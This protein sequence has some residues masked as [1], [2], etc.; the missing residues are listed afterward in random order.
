MPAWQRSRP[1]GGARLVKT[2]ETAATSAPDQPPCGEQNTLRPGS[3]CSSEAEPEIANIEGK[4]V[5][6]AELGDGG[7]VQ[8][9]VSGAAERGGGG[10]A[11][12]HVLPVRRSLLRLCRP[13]VTAEIV[14]FGWF[15]H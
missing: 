4:E 12:T 14:P 9:E 8:E 3:Q 5:S 6:R 1:P 15:R 2:Q 7:H 13:P 10:G 11:K